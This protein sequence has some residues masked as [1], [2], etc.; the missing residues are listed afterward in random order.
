MHVS[1]HYG[2]T[3]KLS[4][5]LTTPSSVALITVVWMVVTLAH[6]K[7]PVEESIVPALGFDEL[8]VA[9]SVMST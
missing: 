5:L 6:V 3:E 2:V 4:P 8:H 7:N 9:E 1:Q